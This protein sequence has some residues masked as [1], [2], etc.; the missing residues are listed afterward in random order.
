MNNN[1]FSILQ[2][3]I[4]YFF[5]PNLSNDRFG[6]NPQTKICR[7]QLMSLHTAY[8]IRC[9][10]VWCGVGVSRGSTSA[11]CEEAD[12]HAVRPQLLRASRLRMSF[13]R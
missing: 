12:G 4:L 5:N 10:V 2:M 6:F 8:N 11:S 7:V 1:V 3:N 9:G 13:S